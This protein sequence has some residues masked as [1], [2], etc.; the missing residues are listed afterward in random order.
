MFLYA[1]IICLMPFQAHPLVSQSFYGLTLI[2]VV[3]ILALLNCLW[4]NSTRKESSII[5]DDYQGKLYLV[6]LMIA[7]SSCIFKNDWVF[8]P[9]RSFISFFIFYYVTKTVLVDMEK[10]RITLFL[11]IVSMFVASFYIF[12]EYLYFRN[13]YGEGFRPY[14]GLF[15][16]PNYFALSAAISLP[17]AYYLYKTSKSFFLKKIALFIL[18]AISAAVLLSLSRGAFLGIAGALLV[19]WFLSKKKMKNL[20][21]IFS[22]VLIGVALAPERLW[23]RFS[24]T[25]VV[26]GEILTD[27]AAST[28]RRWRLIKAGLG[29]TSEYPLLGVGLGT[30]RFYSTQYEK[31]LGYPGLAH[32]SYVEL[33]AELGIPALIL[34]LLIIFF[35]IR[36][37][38]HIR[39]RY[40]ENSDPHFLATSLLICIVVFLISG[41]FLSGQYTKLFWLIIF[42]VPSLKKILDLE[43]PSVVNSEAAEQNFIEKIN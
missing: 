25:Q 2:K 24:Q 17:I 5:F 43:D 37:L 26:E 21:V 3:G 16:D 14:G 12:K 4:Q 42:I 30:Y 11:I 38:I 34:F 40:N 15:G 10:V 39:N 8:S 29:M 41:N 35:S 36:D 31:S 32:N 9:F 22:V 6:L 23:D 13:I 27:A 28:T 7:F 19:S 20:L 1:L 18:I 33:M